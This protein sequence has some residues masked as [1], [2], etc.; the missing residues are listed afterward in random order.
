MCFHYAYMFPKKYDIDLKFYDD[1]SGA[2]TW[3]RVRFGA[4]DSVP[5]IRRRRFGA[6]HFD[7]GTI[8][9]QNFF[10]RFVVL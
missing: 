6:G 8:R 9:R 3:G 4:T 5:P 1:F 7:A 2:L 10:F